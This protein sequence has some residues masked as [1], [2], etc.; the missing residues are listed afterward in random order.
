MEPSSIGTEIAVETM[1]CKNWAVNNFI[2]KSLFSVV[3]SVIS[4]CGTSLT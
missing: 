2:C 3:K 4:S 1:L